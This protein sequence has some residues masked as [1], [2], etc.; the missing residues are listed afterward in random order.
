MSCSAKAAPPVPS[1]IFTASGDTGAPCVCASA[2]TASRTELA[3]VI[4]T[5]LA[6][7]RRT[8]SRR[9]MPLDSSCATSSLMMCLALFHRTADLRQV[10]GH[11]VDFFGRPERAAPHHAVQRGLP[12]AVILPQ[13]GPHRRRVALRALALENLLSGSLRRGGGRL[14]RRRGILCPRGGDNRQTQKER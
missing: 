12:R 10:V 14:R 2:S 13:R 1:N 3:A 7:S 11:R 9:E 8:K 4:V 5:P 6:T